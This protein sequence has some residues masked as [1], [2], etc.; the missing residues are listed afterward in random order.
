MAF[1]GLAGRF[2]FG[3]V[4]STLFSLAVIPIL[5]ENKN[6]VKFKQFFQPS[7]I[8]CVIVSKND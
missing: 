3:I 7:M 1:S 5:L 8:K 6:A 2:I 4:A